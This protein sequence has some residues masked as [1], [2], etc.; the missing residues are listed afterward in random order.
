M[1]F[2]IAMAARQTEVIPLRRNNAEIG[3]DKEGKKY[4]KVKFR[5]LKATSFLQDS[6]AIIAGEVEVALVLAYLAVFDKCEPNGDT[7]LW[8]KVTGPANAL[9]IG[10]QVI[11]KNTCAKITVEV[12]TYLGLPNPG[13][14]PSLQLVARAVTF[15]N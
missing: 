5:R 8:R 14:H 1:I 10:K 12:A 2:A 15:V 6:Y 7:R 11:G 3:V 4:V 9:Q 13:D